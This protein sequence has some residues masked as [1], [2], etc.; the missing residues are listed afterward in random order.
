MNKTAR[1]FRRSLVACLGV[2]AIQ[3]SFAAS[4]FEAVRP[5]Y[6]WRF[7]QD[8][9]AHKTV[10]AER[11]SYR[12]HLRT[13]P[14]EVFDV[15]VTFFRWGLK[16]SP[17]TRSSF[18]PTH[19]YF[20]HFGVSDSA[21]GIFWRAE[22]ANRP[23]PGLAGS[24]EGRLEVWNEDWRAVYEPPGH[25]VKA[26]GDRYSL[27]LKVAS[28]QPPIRHGQGGWVERG[29]LA[30]S[31]SYSLPGLRAEGVLRV[32]G[33]DKPVTGEAWMDHEFFTAGLAEGVAGWDRM[34]FR[35][36]D[37]SRLMLYR[38]R[39]SDNTTDGFS[40]GTWV[41]RD[42]KTSHL[43]QKDFQ[44]ES[45]RS[46][47]SPRTGAEYPVS[48]KVSLPSRE[49][50]FEVGAPFE[51]HEWVP[52]KSTQGVYWEGPLGGTGARKGRPVTAQGFLEM[53]GYDGKLLEF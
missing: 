48:W 49:L 5:G 16:P 6:A 31:L 42:G 11:W 34:G 53:T 39:L 37:G 40:W 22:K 46:W 33:T 14:G 38:L 21:K 10:R 17:E 23:G 9:G 27:D 25:H 7:P 8:H 47:K 28:A 19:L 13:E 41:E 43:V 2:C 29:P 24:Q 4:L 3:V 12:A 26:S 51:N 1:T 20:A 52:E 36:S 18:E 44:L 35:L 50:I 32:D 15:Q 30:A 45:L